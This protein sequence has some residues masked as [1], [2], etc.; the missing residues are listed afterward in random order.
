MRGDIYQNLSGW[1]ILKLGPLYPPPGQLA[2][3]LIG[4][5]V[6]IGGDVTHIPDQSKFLD[7]IRRRNVAPP[8]ADFFRDRFVWHIL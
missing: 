6:G 8:A 5:G 4:K 7:S 1:I 3:I 2:V